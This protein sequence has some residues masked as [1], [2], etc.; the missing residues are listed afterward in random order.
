MLL[1]ATRGAKAGARPSVR[2]LTVLFEPYEVQED[3]GMGRFATV[4][5]VIPCCS[6]DT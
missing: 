4:P 1:S 6:S 5:D 3:R 2:V